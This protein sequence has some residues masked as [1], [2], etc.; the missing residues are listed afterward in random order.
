MVALLLR[1]AARFIAPTLGSGFEAAGV[2]REA[3]VLFVDIRGFTRLSQAKLAYDIVHIL[4]SFFAAVGQAI[5][6][7]GGRVDKYIGDG[8]MAVFEHPSGLPG[9][10]QAAVEA[11]IAVDAELG[12]VNRQLADEIAEPLRLAMGLHGGRLVI[13]RIGWGAAALPT[14]IG[15]AVNIA[16]GS[17][18][19]RSR[20]RR[21]RRFQSMRNR[22]GA[23]ARGARV[24]E[25]DIRGLEAL[26]PVLLVADVAGLRRAKAAAAES[27]T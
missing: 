27:S 1:P 18:A 10:S 11:V 9:A 2:D 17:R 5:E 25:V 24:N 20:E 16:S 12:T 22:G 13:G 14:V 19:W 23:F 8:S 7:T 4:N 21:T 15:P 6:A 3:V 26:F